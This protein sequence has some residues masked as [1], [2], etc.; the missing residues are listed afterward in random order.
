KNSA[1][2]QQTPYSDPQSSGKGNIESFRYVKH[3]DEGQRTRIQN[4]RQQNNDITAQEQNRGQG[5]GHGIVP[6]RQKLGEGSEPHL[7]IAWHQKQG[8]DDH[9]NSSQGFP[10]HD[11]Y[12][13]FKRLAVE[14]YDLFGRQIG[15]QQR[16]C[17]HTCCQTTPTQ[18]ISV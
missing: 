17:D 12:S 8:G 7:Q 16:T 5:F 9:S 15:H 4:D 3:R 6:A 10:G 13:L 18:K 11:K 2:D 1:Y 14:S